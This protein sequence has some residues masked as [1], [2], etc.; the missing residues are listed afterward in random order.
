MTNSARHIIA[1]LLVVIP[2]YLTAIL[3]KTLLNPANIIAEEFLGY[4]MLLSLFGIAVILLLNKYLLKNSFN[5]F[6]I[7]K[8]K[9]IYDITLALLLLGAIYFIQSLSGISYGIWIE[10]DNDRTAMMEL[11]NI[12]FSSFINGII[13]IGPFTWSNEA[14][15]VLSLAFILNNLWAVSSNKTWTWFSIIFAAL[16]FSLLQINNGYSAIIDSFL[17]ISFSNFIYFHYR[18]ILPLFIA[19][20]LFQMIDLIAYWVYMM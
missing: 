9:F 20:T 1:V 17:L 19:A 8:R 5:V 12:V 15:A 4:Y 18:S 7:G 13:I 10:Q 3:Q 14:F 6:I 2:F 11:L 16:L